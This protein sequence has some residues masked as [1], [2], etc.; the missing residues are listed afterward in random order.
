MNLNDL[1]TL[2]SLD[3]KLTG[4]AVY[5]LEHTV[6]GKRLMCQTRNFSK[7]LFDQRQYLARGRHHNPAVQADLEIDGARAFR[8]VLLEL[9]D[10]PKRLGLLKRV[11]VE[12]A[13]RKGLAYNRPESMSK[14]SLA[15]ER[16]TSG[17][18]EAGS[19]EEN[20]LDEALA[21]L[22]QLCEISKANPSAVAAWLMLGQ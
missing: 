16:A 1:I 20:G 13:R 17:S 14:R 10:S 11:Y 9:V 5:A 12:E 15:N 8:F 19:D 7:R 6:S 3:G 4:C 2:A 22:K 21:R 18:S